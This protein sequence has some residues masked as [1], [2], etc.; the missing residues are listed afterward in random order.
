MNIQRAL[1]LTSVAVVLAGGS[2]LMA[3]TTTGGLSGKI[4]DASG[5]AVAGAR[6][7]VESQA[8]F[9]ARVFTTNAKGEYRA[10]LLPVGNYT[11]KVSCD[12]Y[13]GRTVSDY[14]IGVGTNLSLDVAL[15]P[16]ASAGTTVEVV[17][18]GAQ[19]SKTEDKISVNFSAEQLLQLPTS[20]SFDGA[21]ALAPGVS[22]SGTSTSIRGGSAGGFSQV[23]YRI[24]GIDVQD[25][26]TGQPDAMRSN[27]K[28]YEPLP[29]SI[30]DVQVVLSALNARNGRTQGGQVNVVTRT[31]SNEFSGSIRASLSRPSWTTNLPKGPV[32][33]DMTQSE[34]HAVESFSRY[35]DITFSGPII[36]DRLWFYVGT[37]LQPSASDTNT[38]GWN[39]HAEGNDSLGV[40]DIARYPLHSFGHFPGADSVIM[41][42]T[43]APAGF[44]F[45]NL[46]TMSDWGK[47]VPKNTKYEKFE[48]KFTG[49]VTASHTLSLTVL[50]DKAVI[51]GI[52]GERSNGEFSINKEFM[53]DE[54]DETNAWTLAWNGSIGDR[55]FIEARAFK[56]RFSQGD[57]TGPTTYPYSVQSYLGTGDRDV[58]IV[59][60]TGTQQAYEGATVWYGP[61]YAQRSSASI[62]PA[63]RG[64][65][66]INLN[67]RTFQELAGQHEID[68]GFEQFETIHQFGR[69][70]NG[71]RNFYN[72]GFL[73]NPTT[74]DYRY[75]TM[76]TSETPEYILD[77][78][79][80][81]E[82]F[83]QYWEAMRGPGAHMER[84]W[85]GA[86]E[87]K[88]KSQAFWF[89]DNWTVNSK[90]N[91]MLG[92]RANKFK[93][94]DTDGSQQ[95]NLSITEPRFQVKFNPDGAGKEVL[96]FSY[97]KLA[98]AYSDEMAAAFR[99]NGWYT[100]T[101]HGWRGLPGQM[102]LDDPNIADDP[103]FGVRWVDYDTLTDINNYDPMPFM[104]LDQ[105]QTYKTDGLEV[106][107][108]LEMT[109]GYQR[110]YETGYVR[111]TA[112]E[113]KYKKE[114]VSYV[115]PGWGLEYMTE[116]TDPSGLTDFTQWGQ[117]LHFLNSKFDKTY[118][119]IELAWMENLSSRL[120]FGG[121]ITYSQMTGRDG[122]EYYNYA[123]LKQATG[124][125]DTDY[126]PDGLL[127]R[128]VSARA[129]LTY[130]HP[131]GKGNVSVSA[132]LDYAKAGVRSLVGVE[133][134]PQNQILD[135]FGNVVLEPWSV[136]DYTG[137]SNTVNPR[138]NRY[139]GAVGA[140][141]GGSDWFNVDLR[142][143][144][145]IP[146]KGK[147]TL[148]AYVQVNNLF[149]R[150]LRTSVYDWG[151]G[152][153]GRDGAD[154]IVAGV[155]LSNFARPWGTANNHSYYTGGRTFTEF[156]VGLKF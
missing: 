56:S 70:R 38:L 35:T 101:V 20:R 146:L 82:A 156:S 127:S 78:D 18:T 99:S 113:R 66:A 9:Q 123:A 103:L 94:Y 47:T 122:L 34:T 107:Y 76:Y 95:A 141:H 30:E 28:L 117:N 131:I 32:D 40:A 2:S 139:Y 52:S 68:F 90:I 111:M 74:H 140:Y 54:T 22:G 93:V 152:E 136:L 33:G 84:F 144:G 71:D 61:I 97:A 10:Q 60:T 83:M 43:G 135:E 42:R 104:I 46:R 25:G 88:N 108:A 134:L 14:R 149:N 15:K 58:R 75:A 50:H 72:G 53:G 69:E 86:A 148:T 112:V 11:I 8:L 4:T 98:S 92:L 80:Q 105:R 12:G 65:D 59:Q 121:N 143:Q 87:A 57:V 116:K 63:K 102:G 118:R 126:A 55:W 39:G 147:L 132:L 26:V 124:T 16:M 145:Q 128:D 29:D 155:P 48:G 114:W 21:L 31:G 23:L 62:T 130:V 81:N 85:S 41:N 79:D 137:P 64:N 77:W 142:L 138:M 51:S 129:H 115:R 125:P 19:E 17:A 13:L 3:Q 151:Y 36:K 154:G 49:M 91:V 100:R 133:D 120:S 7:S 119:S 73:Y 89:N 96:S 153:E 1:C 150:I 110:N 109:L 45:M 37:R 24:D 44:E 106:P 6:V 27:A 5:K 67:V